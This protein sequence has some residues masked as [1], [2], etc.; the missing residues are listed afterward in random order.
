MLYDQT[1]SVSGDWVKA[2]EL[3]SGTRAGILNET[4]RVPSQ[5]KDE[6]GNV[7]EQDIA[8]VKFEGVGERNVALNRATINALVAA[9]GRDSNDWIGK[10]LTVQTEKM[11]VGGK[12]VTALFLVPEGFELRED[13]GGYLEIVTKGI[14]QTRDADIPVI[15][16]EDDERPPIRD[17]DLPF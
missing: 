15:A 17:T 12:R 14:P 10:V 16:E 6:K 9:F 3:K 11:L 5:F 1:F 7:K 4:K 2:A 13:S 8:K